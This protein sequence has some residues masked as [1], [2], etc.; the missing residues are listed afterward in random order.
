MSPVKP[1]RTPLPATYNLQQ[2]RNVVVLFSFSFSVYI[3]FFSKFFQLKNSLFCVLQILSLITASTEKYPKIW[4]RCWDWW[5]LN[6]DLLYGS[7]PFVKQKSNRDGCWCRLKK[8]VNRSN[9][10]GSIVPLVIVQAW[11]IRAFDNPDAHQ[12]Q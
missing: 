1:Y 2:H 6:G 7:T 9:L 4:I 11:R 3:F 8:S 12:Y 10:I 5:L